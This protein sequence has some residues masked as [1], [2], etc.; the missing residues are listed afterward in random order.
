MPVSGL[1]LYESHFFQ[2]VFSADKRSGIR[3]CPEATEPLDF[4]FG[5]QAVLLCG[6]I[7]LL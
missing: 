2:N 5:N 6:M 7:I 3:I 4:R 1:F